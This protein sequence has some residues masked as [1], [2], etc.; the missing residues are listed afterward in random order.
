VTAIVNRAARAAATG[1]LGLAALAGAGPL[2]AQDSDGPGSVRVWRTP[3]GERMPAPGEYLDFVLARRARLGIKLNLQARE[4]DSIGAYVDAVTPG[5]PAAK[6]GI[7]SGD[8]I[9]KLDGTSLVSNLKVDRGSYRSDRS[10]PGLRLI[11]LSARLEANDTVAVELRRGQGWKERRTVK[12]VTEAEPEDFAL[13][14]EG[15]GRTFMFRTNP[16]GPGELPRV[17]AFGGPDFELMGER[18]PFMLD[19]PLGH[20]E[21]ASMNPDLGQYFG[22]DEGVLVVSAPK[23]GKLNL[24]GGDVILS[25]DGRKV[26]SP[27]QLMRILRSYEES[28]SFKLEVLRNRHRETVTGSLGD[29][30]RPR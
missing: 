4:T 9:T 30:S 17:Q 2:R 6:A 11:E 5:G 15:P 28:E 14:G 19:S 8:V 27:S 16:T 29:Q 1:L 3:S 18:M 10:L 23:E 13:R 22:T 25:V 20:L 24:K 26:A 21:F 12:V 7:R